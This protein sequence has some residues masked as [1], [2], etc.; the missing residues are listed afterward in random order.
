MLVRIDISYPHQMVVGGQFPPSPSTV[1][2]AIIAA[3]GHRLDEI[4]DIL[5]LMEAGKCIRIVYFDQGKVPE[6]NLRTALPR[7]PKAS[8]VKIFEFGNPANKV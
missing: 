7:M 6:I 2:Q 1:F 5:Q 4:G 8:E 3:N